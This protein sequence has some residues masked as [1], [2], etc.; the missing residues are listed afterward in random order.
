MTQNTIWQH[1]IQGSLSTSHLNDLPRRRNDDSRLCHPSSGVLNR[2][3]LIGTV[4]WKSRNGTAYGAQGC[5]SEVGIIRKIT[6]IRGVEENRLSANGNFIYYG[7]NNQ[8]RIVNS[9]IRYFLEALEDLFG[10]SPAVKSHV[11][12]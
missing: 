7:N 10:E 3:F 5:S 8:F 2:T 4:P 1:L 12:L 9:Q 6:A 11:C